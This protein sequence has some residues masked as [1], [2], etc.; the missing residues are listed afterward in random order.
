M[1]LREYDYYKTAIKCENQEVLDVDLCQYTNLV[2][3]CGINIKRFPFIAAEQDNYKLFKII[4]T[5]FVILKQVV[6]R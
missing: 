3:Y 1:G 6:Y 2:K 5:G 4:I